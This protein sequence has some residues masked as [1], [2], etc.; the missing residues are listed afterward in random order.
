MQILSVR[1][2]QVFWV[3]WVA[4]SLAPARAC[5]RTLIPDPPHTP[6]IVVMFG[7]IPTIPDRGRLESLL[8][9]RMGIP[10]VTILDRGPSESRSRLCPEIPKATILDRGRSESRSRFLSE[11]PMATILDRGARKVGS[12]PGNILFDPKDIFL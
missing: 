4:R 5:A 3:C 9:V 6:H 12:G 1:G 11:I 10:K 7:T 2:M 8:C